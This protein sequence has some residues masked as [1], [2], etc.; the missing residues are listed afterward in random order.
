LQLTDAKIGQSV[1]HP[2]CCIMNWRIPETRM[3]RNL[4]KPIEQSACI[5]RV[6]LEWT[7]ISVRDVLHGQRPPRTSFMDRSPLYGS[8]WWVIEGR[9]HRAPPRGRGASVVYA[10][11]C[12]EALKGRGL[13]G[14]VDEWA[15]RTNGGLQP[16]GHTNYSMV[17][18]GLL[19][20]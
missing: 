16:D 2:E 19:P 13:G 14:G 1:P 9:S 8:P 11:N 18:Q 20:T 15:S 3:A 17:L 10:L 12:Q 5:G 6:L 7:L 4:G